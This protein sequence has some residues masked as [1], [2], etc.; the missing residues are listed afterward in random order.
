MAA[1]H[2]PPPQK[3]RVLGVAFLGMALGL[4]MVGAIADLWWVVAAGAA[5]TAL[6]AWA[7]WNPAWRP[8]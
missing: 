3:L 4:V 8:R 5:L 2:E 7:L 1:D 6:I